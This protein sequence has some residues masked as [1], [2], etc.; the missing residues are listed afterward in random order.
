SEVSPLG[1][2]AEL[3]TLLPTLLAFRVGT[4]AVE[5][6]EGGTPFVPEQCSKRKRLWLAV[7]P[8]GHVI[9]VAHACTWRPCQAFDTGRAL[10]LLKIKLL[11]PG[12]A[13]TVVNGWNFPAAL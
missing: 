3:I 5:H 9:C 8:R 10:R 12:S 4:G 11:L 6:A 7:N 2:R 1:G 13:N